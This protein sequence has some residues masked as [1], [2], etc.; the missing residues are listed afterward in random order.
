LSYRA[1][2]VNVPKSA[3]SRYAGGMSVTF[4]I[5]EAGDLPS[6]VALL[7]D[8]PIGSGRESV[9]AG[10][11]GAYRAAFE[12]I[13]RDPHND[14]LVA[15]D[16]GGV[17]GC[18]QVTITPGLT[19]TGA[20]RATF[21]GVRIRKDRRGSGV[22]EALLRRAMEIARERGAGLFQLTTDTRRP[23]ARRFYERLGFEA[24]HHG[25]KLRLT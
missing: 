17:I 13:A 9:A 14:I 2:R 22:G 19:H 11:L 1:E 5:A 3:G 7:A 16:A 12:A 15:E 18:V 25:M 20:T 21:E 10:E 6:L 8:D 24:T 23:E 4:R